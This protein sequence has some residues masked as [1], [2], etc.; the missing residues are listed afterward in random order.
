MKNFLAFAMLSLTFVAVSLDAD[1][2][3]RF[4]GGNNIG[5]QRATPNNTAAPGNAAAPAAPGGTAAPSTPAAPAPTAA[6]GA[7]PAKPSFMGR[8]GGLLA[9]LGIGALLATMFGAQMGPIMGLLLVGLF[10]AAAAF[11]VVRLFAAR[12]TAAPATANAGAPVQFAGIASGVAPPRLESVEPAAALRGPSALS[13]SEVEPFLRTAKTSFIRLQAANDSK[14]LADIR[15]YTTPEVYAEIA[16]QI[17]E[18]GEAPQ[19]TEVVMLDAK[20]VDDV[21]EDDQA[22]ASVHFSGL[23]RENDAATPSPFDEIWHVRKNLRERNATW[24]IAGIQQAA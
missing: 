9:G 18:R 14:D 2:A 7:L 20:L 11:M 13:P 4:G 23:I 17:S 5:K 12:K 16:M 1:A 15:D 19:K 21:I 3:K 10:F 22:I 24:Q 8:W 6:P